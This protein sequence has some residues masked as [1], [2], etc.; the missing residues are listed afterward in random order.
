MAERRRSSALAEDGSL[1]SSRAGGLSAIMG[2]VNESS[3]G[4]RGQGPVRQLREAALTGD[5]QAFNAALASGAQM[6]EADTGVEK[7]LVALAV[8]SGNVQLARRLLEAGRP[9]TPPKEEG[10]KRNDSDH[11]I[12]VAVRL[13][14]PQMVDLLLEFGAPEWMS[15][16]GPRGRMHLLH[17]AV[18]EGSPD[19]L[20]LLLARG[21]DPNLRTPVVGETALMLPC[22]HHE[23]EI[24]QTLVAAGGDLSLVSEEGMTALGQTLVERR[25]HM[26]PVL[27]K[28]GAD[29]LA[30]VPKWNYSAWGYAIQ[31]DTEAQALKQLCK[32]CAE[33]RGPGY[34]RSL[35][36]W[37]LRNKDLEIV[38]MAVAAGADVN[39]SFGGK[40]V[41]QVLGRSK[42]AEPIVRELKSAKTVR[43][44][45]SAFDD[46]PYGE[47]APPKGSG[48][49]MPL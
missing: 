48:G 10:S 21:V 33:L 23:E 38:R 32:V 27:V 7:T 8:E 5:E 2:M 16:F 47:P 19:V 49:P 4:L 46:E 3:Y 28:A 34:A 44:I 6:A 18:V 39:T 17:F 9:V 15:V 26:I 37:G 11:P 1:L 35:L 13:N 36:H 43:R 14:D 20:R 12:R 25:T 40:T 45:E 24:V 42:A 22:E 31:R 30:M 29:P 41:W